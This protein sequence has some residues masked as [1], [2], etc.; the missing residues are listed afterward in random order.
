MYRAK[1]SKG[2]WVYGTNI[3]VDKTFCNKEVNFITSKDITGNYVFPLQPICSE[4][5]KSTEYVDVEGK[6]LFEGD[7]II[8]KVDWINVDENV[9][10]TPAKKKVLLQV[11]KKD[12]TFE[13]Q[14]VK[15][16][17]YETE[18]L[19]SEMIDNGCT[20][21]NGKFPNKKDP[22]VEQLGNIDE[23]LIVGNILDTD[24]ISLQKLYEKYILNIT[25][26]DNE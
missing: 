20:G 16:S 26:N 14:I 3:L 8:G 9:N 13:L 11:V 6:E 15:I 25:I 21:E 18:G 19:I 5:F 24:S 4:V 1:N 22:C 7:Y 23:M 17:Y 12:N 10:I 2:E